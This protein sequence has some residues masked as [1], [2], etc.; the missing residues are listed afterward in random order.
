MTAKL[1]DMLPERAFSFQPYHADCKTPFLIQEIEFI[2]K[3]NI[4]KDF[5]DPV[6]QNVIV[7]L[8]QGHLYLLDDQE[9]LDLSVPH[10]YLNIEFAY[11][12]KLY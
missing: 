5:D 8:Q 1:F 6:H 9:S 11:M 4:F 10:L 7:G 12:K 3:M 2:S